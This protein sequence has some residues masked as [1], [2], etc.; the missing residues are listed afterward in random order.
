MFRMRVILVVNDVADPGHKRLPEDNTR[1]WR[2]GLI[3]CSSMIDSIKGL[4]RLVKNTSWLKD[5][6]ADDL[7]ELPRMQWRPAGRLM[8]RE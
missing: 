3:V 6:A 5:F 4:G 2:V 1:G 7:Q 8:H